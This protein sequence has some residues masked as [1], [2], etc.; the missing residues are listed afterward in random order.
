MF[1]KKFYLFFLFSFFIGCSSLQPATNTNLDKIEGKFSMFS[2]KT[3]ISGKVSFSN[4]KQISQI[5]IS[6]NNYPK[7]FFITELREGDQKKYK[8]NFN[9]SYETNIVKNLIEELSIL[10]FTN[11]LK[12][13]CNLSECTKFKTKNILISKEEFYAEKKIKKI[14][15]SY[16]DFKFA[17]VFKS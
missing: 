7:T 5:K 3:Y 16:K 12:E 9:E 17:I 4:Q 1:F 11:W 10:K 6:L 15:G 13:V 14:I 2:N 8:S